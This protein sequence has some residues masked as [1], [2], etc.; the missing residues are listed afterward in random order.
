[1]T[2]EAEQVAKNH[3]T[4]KKLFTLPF[5]FKRT[6][7]AYL[8]TSEPLAGNIEFSE[9]EKSTKRHVF[10]IFAQLIEFYHKQRNPHHR[11]KIESTLIYKVGDQIIRDSL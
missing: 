5:V 2:H 3:T 7:I 8:K 6:R 10:D 11:E 4:Y 1:M 9:R